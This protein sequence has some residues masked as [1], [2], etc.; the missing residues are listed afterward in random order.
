MATKRM[1][2]TPTT[3]LDEALAHGTA[4]HERSPWRIRKGKCQVGAPVVKDGLPKK[5]KDGDLVLTWRPVTEDLAKRTW[6]ST[7]W[8]LE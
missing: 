5:T 6:S 2:K 1:R 8:I 4:R 7:G 3:R